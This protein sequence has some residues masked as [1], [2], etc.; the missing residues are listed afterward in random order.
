MVIS[1]QQLF[2]STVAL[3]LDNYLAQQSGTA[4]R[5]LFSSPVVPLL[6]GTLV[7]INIY[8]FD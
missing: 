7:Y 8:I 4:L 3:L 2:S 6:D 1:G 5:Q